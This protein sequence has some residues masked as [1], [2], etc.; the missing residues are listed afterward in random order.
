MYDSEKD[1]AFKAERR[2]K[3]LSTAFRLFAER[4][5]DA[6]SMEEIARESGCGRRTLNR[7][8]DNKPVLVVAVS[9]WAWER[10]REKNEMR[11]PSRNFEGMSA[12]AVFEFYLDSFLELYR[13]RM[14]LLRFN[15]F[16]NV[17]IRSEKVDQD[18]L[19]PF[20]VF[21]QGIRDKFHK[22]Y[23][24]AGKDRTVRTDI[25][26]EEIFSTTLHLMLAAV[27]RYAV[28][29]VYIPENSFD[30][31]KELTKQKDMLIKE[32]CCGVQN[33]TSQMEVL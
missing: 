17:Y 14:D 33:S 24:L 30:A 21:I 23:L 7:Y 15:Q 22:M 20:Q 10:F 8:Y 16:F 29:L 31:L 19:K 28:G 4:K 9:A 1:P 12:A 25:P 27:T 2:E 6:V 3:I 32:Y 26:E 11:R 18:T 5:I 13:S